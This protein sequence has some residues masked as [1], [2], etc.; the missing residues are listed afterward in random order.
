MISIKNE[1][2]IEFMR[3]SGKITYGALSGLKDFIKPGMTELEVKYALDLK[4]YTDNK[5]A[6]ISAQII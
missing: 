3:K 4:K 2:E 5:L 1:Q 6:E